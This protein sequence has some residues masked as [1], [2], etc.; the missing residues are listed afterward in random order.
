MESVVASLT[1][2][3]RPTFLHGMTPPLD[4]T[5]V[6]DAQ[7][8]ADKFIARS[9]NLASD[10]FIV[11]DIQDEPS[12]SG[13]S[14]PFPFRQ[15]MDSSTYAALWLERP[16]QHG[17]DAIN[18]VGRP[19]ADAPPK[20]PSMREAMALVDASKAA[21]GAPASP[22]HTDDHAKSRG[23]AAPGEHE[24]ML[25]KHKAGAQW[26][27]SQAVYD[28]GPTIR[29]LRDFGAACGPGPGARKVVLT[30]APC[31]RAKTMVFLKWLGV[32][33]PEDAEK[34]I[35]D[36]ESPVDE[37]SVSIFKKEIEAVHDLFR[38][39]QAIALDHRGKAWKV[40][41]SGPSARRARTSASGAAGGVPAV[42]LAAAALAVSVACLLIVGDQ[43]GIPSP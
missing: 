20:G 22:R 10:G 43:G 27:I 14:R 5:S 3:E 12:R 18:V 30:F 35:L 6:G 8:I 34:R 26:F 2:P 28:A 11:Y 17:H 29:L 38:K 23:K 9:R 1:D 16:D 40:T 32:R 19:S 15:L 21:F 39:T 4:S 25:R 37:S 36:A 13:A 24:N 41:R 33:V 31:G 42:A 7:V